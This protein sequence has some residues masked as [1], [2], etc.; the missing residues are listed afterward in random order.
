MK[1]K[2]MRTFLDHK[3]ISEIKKD[4]EGLEQMLSGGDERKRGDVGNFDHSAKRLNPQEVQAEIMHKKKKLQ[5]GTPTKFT[6]EAQNK[7]Y[8]YAKKLEKYIAEHIP[9][10]T[11]VRYPSAGDTA[12]KSLGFERSVKERMAWMQTKINAGAF[13][14]VHPEQ[15]YHHIMRRIDPNYRNKD[16]SIYTREKA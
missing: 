5:Q 10:E 12:D 11:H 16:F 14:N 13:G 1:Q 4:I 8:A 6:G 3:Q 7:A 2:S 15:A 9:R